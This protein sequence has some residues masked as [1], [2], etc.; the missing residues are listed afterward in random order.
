MTDITHQVPSSHDAMIHYRT[1][2]RPCSRTHSLHR[3]HS[4]H[5][6]LLFDPSYLTTSIGPLR[7]FHPLTLDPLLNP[8]LRIRLV[9][10][11]SFVQPCSRATSG[12]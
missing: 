4:S 3:L 11:S 10:V 7:S 5:P 12:R 9:S 2:S 8:A 6:R 1:P